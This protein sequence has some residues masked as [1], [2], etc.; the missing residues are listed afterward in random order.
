MR[1]TYKNEQ[2]LD[3]FMGE[4][5]LLD[6]KIEKIEIFDAGLATHI[7]ID[8]QMRPSSE[9]QKVQFRFGNCAEFCFLWSAEYQFYNVERMK[10]FQ[11]NDGIYYVSFDPFDDAEVTS[12]D[13]QNF[14]FCREVSANC[15]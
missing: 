9:H 10:F 6:G 8:F 7:H 4:N 3:H 14:I 5:S 11:R 2:L 1:K 12:D 13:D 15:D